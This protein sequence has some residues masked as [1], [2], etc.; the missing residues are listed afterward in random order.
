MRELLTHSR[1]DTF[2][3][4]RRKAWYAY[5]LGMRRI[6]DAKA[7]RMGAAFHDGVAALGNGEG[8]EAAC[9]V[10]GE[11]YANCPDAFDPYEW[12]I[13][14]ETVLRLICA[15]EWRWA[16]A[17]LEYLG[18]T[19][20]PF[21]LPLINPATGKPTPSFDLAGKMDAVV[22]IEDGRGAVKESKML[23]E[24][25]GPDSPLWRRL[26]M[27]HQISL[28]IHTAREIGYKVD[29]VL[30][31]V[32][33]KPTIAPTAVPLLDADGVKIVLDA[34]GERVRTKDG[35]KWRQT[36]STDDG[37]RLLTRTMTPDEWGAKLTAD[38]MERPDY[39]FARVEVPRL[40]QDIE[41]Y[42]YELWDIQLAIRDAQKTGRW[43][44]TV[45]KNCQFCPYFDPCST[46]QQIDPAHPPAGFE[47]LTNV[48]PELG[49]LNGDSPTETA[50]AE[51]AAPT[52][53]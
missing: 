35:K 36:A 9:M 23:G 14:R 28:Y 6:D 25:I 7:L 32:T 2:K 33:R 19:E 20:K 29:T 11:P 41:E 31:D 30:Y 49:E 18:R 50:P 16:A 52:L 48:H 17:P 47:I 42:R 26:R 12:A 45:G 40:D 24:D 1:Q 34:H 22:R 44:R 53:A 46:S 21:R 13:E 37:Y 10:A 27:D 3:T 39:Y 8:N 5:E 51:S 38:I 15:Y 43:Y 4:C